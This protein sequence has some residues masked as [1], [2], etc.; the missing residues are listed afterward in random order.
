MLELYRNLNHNLNITTHAIDIG[1]FTSMLWTF[2][3]REKIIN[4]IEILT[5][6]RFHSLL[7]FLVKLR[8]DLSLFFINSLLY[9]L[10]NYLRKLKEIYYIL[11]INLIWKTRLNEIGIISKFFCF[12]Y[13]LSGIIS[14]PT[15][16]WIDCRFI[17]FEFYNELNFLLFNGTIGDCLDR[18]IIR[19]NE[20]IESL[21]II[22]SII[23]YYFYFFY[24]YIFN[25]IFYFFNLNLNY[26]ETIIINFIYFY[27]LLSFIIIIKLFKFSIESSKGIYS[28][29][30]N[31]NYW[32]INIISNDYL[33]LIQ[34]NKY[35]RYINLGDCIALLGSI[36]SVLGSVDLVI[37][38]Y[39]FIIIF[40][41]IFFSYIFIFCF[42]IY[43]FFLFLFFFILFY[44]RITMNA[45]FIFFYKR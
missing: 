2:E 42:F 1:L 43:Y 6:T 21:K 27:L 41:V 38:Y 19:L 28:I 9:W 5:G 13:G 35:C 12:Y 29:F 22:Y 31:C 32:T 36:D 20:I 7:F 17:G 30:I 18:Y 11:T 45:F 44:F 40:Y 14:R 8:F 24:F 23:Y 25:F 34:L 10:L 37:F 16:I 15:N 4:L 26:M 3:E 33:T 39:F